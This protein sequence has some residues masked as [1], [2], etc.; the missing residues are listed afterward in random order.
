MTEFQKNVLVKQ[1]E[2][3]VNKLTKQFF[4][5]NCGFCNWED[6]YSMAMEGFAL[7]INNY[8]ESRSKMSFTQ[9]AAYAIRNNILTGLNEETRTV[10][11]SAYAQKVVLAQ[12]GTTFNTVSIDHAVSGEDDEMKPREIVM[13]MYEDEKFSNGDIFTYLYNRLEEQF[14]RRDCDMFYKIFGLKGF[15]ETPNK[16]VA[17]E[18]GVSEGLV[19]QRIKKVITWIRQDSDLCE[20]LSSLLS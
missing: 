12:G 7:A 9:Y 2:P 18:Y 19:S 8:D 13:G 17:K 1:Y 6:L 20:V 14:G 4:D 3:L 16:E 5:S 11:L 10:K 15:E